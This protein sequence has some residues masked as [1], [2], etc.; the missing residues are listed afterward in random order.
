M[1]ATKRESQHKEKLR[2]LGKGD[3]VKEIAETLVSTDAELRRKEADKLIALCDAAAE[4][5]EG[6]FDA[7]DDIRQMRRERQ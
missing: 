3:C 1:S 6:A 2:K 4:M 5:W 7:A